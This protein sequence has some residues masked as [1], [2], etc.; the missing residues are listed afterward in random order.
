M[1]TPKTDAE[2]LV[3]YKKLRDDIV[4]GGGLTS[5]T[6]ANRTFNFAD[7]P[8]IE[9]LISYYELRLARKTH[10]IKFGVAIGRNH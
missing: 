10:G 8:Q 2:I 6:I 9:D 5:Y 3:E 7:L 1:A 4:M